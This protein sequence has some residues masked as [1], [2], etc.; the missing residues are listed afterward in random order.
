MIKNQH[1]FKCRF[2]AL[3]TEKCKKFNCP[4]IRNNSLDNILKCFIWFCYK[5][6]RLSLYKTLTFLEE[7]RVK[8]HFFIMISLPK[9]K[10]NSFQ[11]MAMFL[12]HLITPT[13]LNW[14]LRSL[15]ITLCNGRCP[16]Q[17]LKKKIWKL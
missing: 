2:S 6:Y 16:N 13:E 15:T 17:K 12:E 1:C 5:F 7:K 11:N 14:F 10:R 8:I 9:I 4:R 3:V